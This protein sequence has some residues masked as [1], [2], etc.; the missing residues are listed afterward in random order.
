MM[1]FKKKTKIFCIGFNKTGTTSVKKALEDLQYKMGEQSRGEWMLDNWSKRN[2]SDLDSY[3]KTADAFQDAPFSFPF[4][5]AYLDQKFN[6]SKFILTERDSA[7]QW[8]ESLLSF[9]S[10]LWGDNEGVPTKKN[11]EEAK[12]IY[13]GF[14]Y[15]FMKFVY[16]TPDDD[17]YN[18]QILIDAYNNHSYS[19][20]EYFKYREKDLLVLNLR[21][22]GSY[23]KL[24]AFI[25][26]EPLYDDFPWENKTENV[27]DLIGKKK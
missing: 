5:Y 7:E 25:G 6:G 9:H 12:Y 16:N 21:E 2:F 22:K 27:Y 11:L 18:K 23:K 1:V 24:C 20:K 4:T 13:T 26:K 10:K 3:C 8:Y 19:V 15:K 14:P 17:L